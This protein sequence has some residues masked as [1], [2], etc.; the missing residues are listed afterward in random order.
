MERWLKEAF[1]MREL[2]RNKS[3]C[4]SFVADRTLLRWKRAHKRVIYAFPTLFLFFSV[5]VRMSENI[6]P[7]FYLSRVLR[8]NSFLFA[9]IISTFSVINLTPVP[10]VAHLNGTCEYARDTLWFCAS[11]MAPA[12]A[13]FHSDTSIYW[14]KQPRGM[15]QARIWTPTLNSPTEKPSAS[16]PAAMWNLPLCTFL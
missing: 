8:V 6:G 15:L 7:T 5:S 9:D 13:L 16:M 1:L 10:C 14:W 3:K 11:V 2:R 12:T 4:A